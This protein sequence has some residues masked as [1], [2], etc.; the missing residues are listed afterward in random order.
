MPLKKH[1]KEKIKFHFA[2][3]KHTQ[4][5]GRKFGADQERI[6]ALQSSDFTDS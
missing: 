1:G 3:G 6:F 5:N 2:S 4:L